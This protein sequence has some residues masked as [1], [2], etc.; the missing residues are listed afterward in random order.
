[1]HG[2]SVAVQAA[3][4][5]LPEPGQG[6]PVSVLCALIKAGLAS[7]IAPA[8]SIEIRFDI[9]KVPFSNNRWTNYLEYARTTGCGLLLAPKCE[10]QNSGA[11]GVK[12]HSWQSTERVA[13]PTG[14]CELE[15][16]V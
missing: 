6:L 13:W 10:A 3:R 8:V 11:S 7:I 2:R 1:M 5:Y 12:L 16:S 14:V 4:R 9:D 15:A